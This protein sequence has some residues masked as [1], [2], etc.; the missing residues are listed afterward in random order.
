M[1][2]LLS[3]GL[4]VVPGQTRDEAKPL[5]PARPLTK[6]DLDRREA[7]KLY[8]IGLICQREDRLLEATRA[9]ER[10]L[11]LDAEA[12]P[13]YKALIPL[14]AALERDAD[15]LTA[16]RKAV[17]LD[18]DA[19]ETWFIYGRQLKGLGQVK[20]AIAALGKGVKCKGAR[21]HPELLQQMYFELGVM[22]EE[23]RDYLN[24]AAA[25]A[26]TAKILD[27]PEQILAAGSY[28]KEEIDGRAAD[29]YER[30]GR[31]YTQARKYED[32][33]S[34]FKK[35]QTKGHN[36]SGRLN[37]NLAEV[38]RAQGKRTEALVALD[39]Y[40]QLQPQGMEAYET[41]IALLRAL[42]RERDI[43]P[44]LEKY[45]GNDRYNP[46]LKLLLARELAAND[47]A[48]EAEEI[49]LTLARGTPAPDVYRGLFNLYK[50]TPRWGMEK[51]LR[52]LDEALKNADKKN[53]SGPEK[54][55]AAATARVMLAVLRDEPA[56]IKLLLVVAQRQLRDGKTL[57]YQTQHF[58]AVLAGH[59]KQLD[60]AEVFYRECLEN[61]TPE[62]E[63]SIYEGLL[64]VLWQGRKYKAIAAVCRK[65]LATT[66]PGSHVLLH[67]HLAQA[68][69]FLD[70]GE[71]AIVHADKAVALANGDAR[72]RVRLRR[73]ALLSRV[74]DHKRAI[75]ECEAMLK[76]YKQPAEVHDI[77]SALSNVYTAARMYARAEATL[78]RLIKDSPEDATAYNDLGYILADRNKSLKKA[79]EYVRKAIELD[80]KQ[81]KNGAVV[82][83]E[84]KD[85]AAYIDSLGWVLFRR[86]QLEA[87][88]TETERASIL[89]NGDDDPVI[90]DHLGDIYFRL[91]QPGRAR[92]AWEKSLKLYEEVKRRKMD[93]RYQDIKQKLKDLKP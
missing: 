63:A 66:Q 79:E 33:V 48:G 69:P 4:D 7:L 75:A 21:K 32:A 50:N 55:A 85:N 25:F 89:P 35:A 36:R 39:L 29:L 81:K 71:E 16:C 18:P 43:V 11:K 13:V 19:F 8:T 1:V 86:G 37:Y 88:R 47:K 78:E 10:A 9:F 27:K 59:A 62:N 72:R 20:K 45:V 70:Q 87:A 30:L 28:S 64:K 92:V 68:L 3:G 46:G 2:V 23:G 38:Y 26:E 44:A 74:D 84:D 12:V 82:T 56:M 51:V 67:L 15:A 73:V 76:E 17:E 41:K 80:R 61:T 60:A 42:K 6:K 54:S 90:F 53:Q 34:S 24:A 22:Y 93:Q 52:L 5:S 40:L 77:R 31:L 65:G 91:N 14:Y 57:G 83:E 49:Y 58:L